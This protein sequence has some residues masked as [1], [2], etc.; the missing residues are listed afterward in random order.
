GLD[1]IAFGIHVLGVATLRVARASQEW[2]ARP[3]AQNHRLAT[4]VTD[5]LRR[6]AG[7]NRLA[8]VVEI[9]R[10][11][12]FRV[13]AA[14]QEWPARTHPLNHWLAARRAFMLRRYGRFSRGF[15]L[16]SF[17]VLALRIARAPKEFSH[18][19]DFLSERFSALWA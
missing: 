7:Q 19:A 2:A 6:L 13:P 8:L 12:A 1:R 5:V 17:D 18:L 16:R 9:H 3:L 10:G 15:I 14:A 4:F 11:P